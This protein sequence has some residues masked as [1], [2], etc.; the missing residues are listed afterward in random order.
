MCICICIC[1]CLCICIHETML[2]KFRTPY[3]DHFTINMLLLAMGSLLFVFIEMSQ[4]R[5][6]R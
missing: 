4:L 1:I 6:K 2:R 5:S 3:E